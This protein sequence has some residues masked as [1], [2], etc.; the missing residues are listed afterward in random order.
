MANIDGLGLDHE[1]LEQK[2]YRSDRSEIQEQMWKYGSFYWQGGEGTWYGQLIHPELRR[3]LIEESKFGFKR[4]NS[5]VRETSWM[6]KTGDIPFVWVRKYLSGP[7]KR[8]VRLQTGKTT[9]TVR[10][11]GS[12]YLRNTPSE[13]IRLRARGVRRTSLKERSIEKNNDLLFYCRCSRRG[14]LGR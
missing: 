5:V 14:V 12:T 9:S 13:K 1:R 2:K 3:L 6:R 11:H 10:E 4:I 7:E 8:L